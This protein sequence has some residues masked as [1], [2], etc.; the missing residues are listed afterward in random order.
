MFCYYVFN[1]N[2]FGI[3]MKST[4]LIIPLI[5]LL[6]SCDEVTDSNKD[7]ILTTSKYEIVHRVCVDTNCNIIIDDASDSISRSN[8]PQG[9]LT[10]APGFKLYDSVAVTME[11]VYGDRLMNS[12]SKIPLQFVDSTVYYSNV[13]RPFGIGFVY[14]SVVLIRNGTLLWSGKDTVYMR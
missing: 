14:S 4:F 1:N 7:K 12:F 9:K 2:V 8:M 5:I 11:N 6:F 13:Y 3:I 10:Y